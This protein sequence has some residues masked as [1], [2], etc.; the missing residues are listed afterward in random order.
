MQKKWNTLEWLGFKQWNP[1][2]LK[3]LFSQFFCATV[4]KLSFSAS[5]DIITKL[6]KIPND[7]L[8]SSNEKK[9]ETNKAK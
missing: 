6:K 5:L 7:T 9:V 8:K 2:Q 3:A 1:D 4:P